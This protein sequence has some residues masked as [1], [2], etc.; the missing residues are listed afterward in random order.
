MHFHLPL[1]LSRKRNQLNLYLFEEDWQAAIAEVQERHPLDAQKWTNRTGF[2]DGDHEASVLPIHIACSLNAPLEVVRAIVEAYPACLRAKET[3]FKRLPIHVACMFSAP[4]NVIEYL[5]QEYVAGTLEP[6]TLGRLSIHYACNN[7]ALMDV[8]QTLLR[9][10]SASTLYG[11]C[12]GWLPLH[13]AIRCGASTEVVREIVRVCP[14]AVAMKTKK[15]STA[16]SL[17]EKVQAKNK[18]DVIETLN[19]NMVNGINNSKNC[20]NSRRIPMAA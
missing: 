7:G 18:K 1:N 17:A 6:D 8:V 11:D 15:S 13:V 3:S 5:A 2:F 19:C 10:N 14:A 16:L 12:N 9:V 4:V 20:S